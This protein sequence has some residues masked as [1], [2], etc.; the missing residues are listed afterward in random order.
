MRARRPQRARWITISALWLTGSGGCITA[1]GTVAQ[2]TALELQLLGAYED[3]DKS[4]VHAS[5]V[6][7]RGVE[8]SFESLKARAVQMRA[9]QRFNGD[10]VQEL[11]SAG[12]LAETLR[13]SLKGRA[14]SDAQQDGAIQR[15]IARIVREENAAREAILTWAAYVLARQQGLA[16]PSQAQLLELQGAYQRLLAEAARPGHW[17][18]T[19]PG[20][21]AP[22]GEPVP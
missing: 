2:P 6:R 4:L 15:R 13:A 7:A 10:D 11:K 21:F 8:R 14:C 18:E 12:C 3:L 17:L 20:R 22:K 1:A 19:S 9:L 5:S 16:R